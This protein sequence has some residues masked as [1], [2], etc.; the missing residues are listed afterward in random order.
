MEDE[1]KVSLL[2]LGAIGLGLLF[3]ARKKAATP[4]SVVS[5]SPASPPLAAPGF[6]PASPSVTVTP[7]GGMVQ[8]AVGV[9][10]QPE[11]ARVY[12]VRPADVTMGRE[13]GAGGR[14]QEWRVQ[15]D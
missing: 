13:G 8:P 15:E 11:P 14:A 10:A 9:T 6:A 7:Q 2:V 12:D 4:V 3:Q 5:V 1:T